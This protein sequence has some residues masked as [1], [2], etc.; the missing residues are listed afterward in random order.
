MKKKIVVCVLCST[1]RGGWINPSLFRS[2]LQL[3]QDARF[4]FEFE[5]V[6]D[7][8][9]VATAR[10]TAIVRARAHGADV[11]VMLDND[12]VLPANFADILHDAVTT[13]K[14][15]VSLGAGVWLEEGPRIIPGDNGPQ[16]GQ[17]RQTG[18]AGG[19]VLIISSKVWHV[20]ERGPWFR[21][22]TND[23]EVG[24]RR[25]GEDYYFCELVHAH[26]MTVW[27][28]QRVAGHLKTSDAT[29]YILRLQRTENQL[30]R[31]VGGILP[32]EVACPPVFT[33]G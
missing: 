26:G 14:D 24:S 17:F 30:R 25:L 27:T 21:W 7:V 6:C 18:C 20:I 22:L 33:E 31:M 15:V 19:G 5:M 23:D 12:M 4:E 2:L 16:D 32:I 10:N 9:P 11:C 13:Q 3:Q 8:A 28:H 29:H 1:E